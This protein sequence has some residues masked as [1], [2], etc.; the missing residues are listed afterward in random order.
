MQLTTDNEQIY[1]CNNHG[2]W[3][4]NAILARESSSSAK[5]VLNIT[6]DKSMLEETVNRILPLINE[7]NIYTVVGKHHKELTHKVLGE[8]KSAS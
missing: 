2:R 5:T 3:F 4:G 1:V 6:S 7:E 8:T